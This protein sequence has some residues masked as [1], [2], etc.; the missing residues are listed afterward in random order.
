MF[1]RTPD[2]SSAC[3]APRQKDA[4]RMPPPDSASPT[5][6]EL[7]VGRM[8]GS[9]SVSLSTSSFAKSVRQSSRRRSLIAWISSAKTSWNR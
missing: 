7:A 1:F 2:L 8:I 3:S 4:E 5:T 6:F 9:P